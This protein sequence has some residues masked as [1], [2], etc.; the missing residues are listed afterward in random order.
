MIKAISLTITRK[1][2]QFRRK[3]LSIFR[4]PSQLTEDTRV[5]SDLKS[6]R[7]EKFDRCAVEYI[8]FIHVPYRFN[9]FNI[10]C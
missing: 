5:T 3:P 6:E 10:I 9:L 4:L 7:C 1:T 8:S 2:H